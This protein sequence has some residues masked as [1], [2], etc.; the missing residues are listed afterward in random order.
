[1]NNYTGYFAKSLAGHDHSN[2]YIIVDA[3]NEYVYLVDGK[4]K[5]VDN[6]KKKKIK[7]IQI[8]KRTDDTITDKINNNIAL[9]NEDIKYAIKKLFVTAQ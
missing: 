3:D 5:K 9:T 7:H 2:V 1:M 4:L 8:I 6:P